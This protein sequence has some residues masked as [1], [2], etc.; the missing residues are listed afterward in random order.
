MLKIPSTRADELVDS[1]AATR[2]IMAGRPRRE[3]IL[4]PDDASDEIW[5]AHLD[6]AHA[7]V[8]EITP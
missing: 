3:W 4:V 7:Y 2:M 1:G 6:E 5:A 8:D